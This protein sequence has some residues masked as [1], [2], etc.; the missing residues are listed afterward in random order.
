MQYYITQEGLDYLEEEKLRRASDAKLSSKVKRGLATAGVI[1][2]IGLGVKHSVPE[3]GETETNISGRKERMRSVLPSIATVMKNRP[4]A[5]AKSGG[6]TQGPRQ[7]ELP[8]YRAMHPGTT[9]IR[10][11]N[12]PAPRRVPAADATTGT[13]GQKR[14]RGPKTGPSVSDT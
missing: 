3:K 14:G 5:I 12:V 11:R 1:G 2:A 7:E 13:K 10:A 6:S 9:T 8:R 4:S